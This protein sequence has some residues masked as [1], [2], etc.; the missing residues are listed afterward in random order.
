MNKKILLTAGAMLALVA[1]VAAF[2]AF[3]AHV[4]NVTAHIENALSVSTEAIDFGTV[5]PQE[6]V[7]RGFT[8]GLSQ[9]F[10]AEDQLRRGDVWYK[11][12]QKPKPNPFFESLVEA[13]PEC[14][15][16]DARMWCHDN[17]P[18]GTLT[19]HDGTVYTYE[20]LCYPDLCRFLSKVPDPETNDV[21]VPSYYNIG[22]KECA[23]PSPEIATGYLV[24]CHPAH[25]A[26]VPGDIEDCWKVDLKVPPVDGYVGQDWLPS[27]DDW[28]VPT[29][30]VTYGCDLWIEVTSF[31]PLEELPETPVCGDGWITGGEECGEIGGPDCE[32][33]YECIE[34]LCEQI[35]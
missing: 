34:C 18:D 31:S 10:L 29:N 26:C 5:F 16:R 22:T 25:V 7:E 14:V 28:V 12:V 1:G 21:G 35:T 24:K 15:I 9:S 32:G 2:S 27:C 11:I 6:Y 13:C 3:E 30:A 19:L 23:T 33:G 8:V 20:E 4:I 17:E